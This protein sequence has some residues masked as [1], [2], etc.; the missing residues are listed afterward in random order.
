[1]AFKVKI[2]MKKGWSQKI[3]RGLKAGLLEMATDIQRVAADRAPVDS[4]ALRNSGEVEPVRDGYRIRFG[5]ARVP[6]AR[7]RHYENRKN[8]S[9]IGYLAKAGDS[10]A[11]SDTSRYFRRKVDV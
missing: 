7:I 6:Y 8:P 5:S 10:V 1:M 2:D 11:R 3:E 9:S 4:G